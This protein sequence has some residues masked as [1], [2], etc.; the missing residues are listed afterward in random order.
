M[1]GRKKVG[2]RGNDI[3]SSQCYGLPQQN[4]EV[5]ANSG[6][7]LSTVVPYHCNLLSCLS[8]HQMATSLTSCEWLLVRATTRLYCDDVC[9]CT[10]NIVPYLRKY[11]H[12]PLTGQVCVCV[13]VRVCVNMRVF[14]SALGGKVF[15]QT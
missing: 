1:A 15:V 7:Y 12:H 6:G 5:R 9:G 11:G 4:V 8:V 2:W 3:H 13:H 10:R 14:P